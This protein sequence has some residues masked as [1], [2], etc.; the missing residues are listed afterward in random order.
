MNLKAVVFI[1]L[2]VFTAATLYIAEISGS[3][4][5]NKDISYTEPH[6]VIQVNETIVEPQK[7]I[8]TPGMPT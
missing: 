5:T 6:S 8:D 7:E 1:F 3:Q 4:M 2:V